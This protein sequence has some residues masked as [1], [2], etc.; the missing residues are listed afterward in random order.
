MKKW[1]GG[2][3]LIE[4]G[5]RRQQVL[6]NRRW[7]EGV[8]SNPSLALVLMGHLVD[9]PYSLTHDCDLLWQMD[10]KQRYQRESRWGMF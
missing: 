9:P 5:I 2:I 7:H 4:M 6:R 10:I 1:K 8:F 3:R